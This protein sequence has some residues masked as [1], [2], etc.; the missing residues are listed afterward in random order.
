MTNAIRTEYDRNMLIKRITNMQIPFSV[1]TAKGAPRSIESNRLQ[2]MW[3]KEAAEQGDNT[4]EEYRGYCKL[5]FG[6]MIAKEDDEYAEKYDRLIRPMSYQA[7][8]ELMMVP[9]DFPVTR[10][11]TTH[12]TSRYLDLIYTH[13]SSLGIHL[14]EPNRN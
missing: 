10:I 3:L 9:M 2:R 4:A 12:Q 1:S 6:V 7:K 5:H 13:L 8:L 14:T 11:F